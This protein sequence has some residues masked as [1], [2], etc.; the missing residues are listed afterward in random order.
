MSINQKNA[1]I[2]VNFASIKEFARNQLTFYNSF[3]FLS[4]KLLTLNI[5]LKLENK[6]K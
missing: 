4:H 1:I 5:N 6:S 2:S 3:T